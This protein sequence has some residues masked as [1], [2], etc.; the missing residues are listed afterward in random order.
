MHRN[1]L[2]I[3][4]RLKKV[5]EGLRA[6]LVYQINV[7]SNILVLST[8]NLLLMPGCDISIIVAKNSLMEPLYSVLLAKRHIS[9]NNCVII[10]FAA[11]VVWP[12]LTLCMT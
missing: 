1:G 12:L 4:T 10:A 5:I 6:R 7:L 11:L 3:K 2:R 8:C 9:Y